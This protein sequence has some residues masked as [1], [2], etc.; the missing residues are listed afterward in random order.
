MDEV[1]SQTC[2]GSPGEIVGAF[3]ALSNSRWQV[4]SP[5]GDPEPAMPSRSSAPLAATPPGYN[6]VRIQRILI[7]M[8]SQR[9]FLLGAFSESR[10]V[11]TLVTSKLI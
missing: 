6:E 8:V 1:F 4:S 10:I 2:T 3:V 9:Q 5:I 7:K 11:Q